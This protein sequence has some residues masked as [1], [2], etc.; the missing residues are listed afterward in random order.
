MIRKEYITV[1]EIFEMEPW[2]DR[3]KDIKF[4][5]FLILPEEEIAFF[6]EMD[7]NI[8]EDIFIIS[9][10]KFIELFRKGFQIFKVADVEL[11]YDLRSIIFEY[12]SIYRS[13]GYRHIP[14]YR[15]SKCKSFNIKS[16][17]SNAKWYFNA[18]YKLAYN[19]YY[20]KCDISV[21]DITK[22]WDKTFRYF[23]KQEGEEVYTFGY[24]IKQDIGVI[25]NHCIKLK[26][27]DY[28][29]KHP[30]WKSIT[31]NSKILSGRVK[32][33]RICFNPKNDDY[34]DDLV[35][36]SMM[37]HKGDT[38][39]VNVTLGI[40]KRDRSREELSEYIEDNKETIL[41]EIDDIIKIYHT[42]KKIYNRMS[43]QR[44]ILLNTNMD[45]LAVYKVLPETVKVDINEYN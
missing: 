41:K 33:N 43:L 23:D 10:K 9:M 38:I 35:N 14:N 4:K 17:A 32:T 27:E 24:N 40:V 21:R 12:G 25:L 42:T 19:D 1:N 6:S 45:L 2:T 3:A 37:Y 16:A 26:E 30:A 18:L 28:N 20:D 15:D 8:D 22:Y 13:D 31:D 11:A 5:Y 29:K 34:N 39:G 7:R 44:L 36:D